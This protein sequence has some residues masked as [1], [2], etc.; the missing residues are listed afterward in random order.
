[1]REILMFETNPEVQEA[2]ERLWQEYQGVERGTIIPWDEIETVMGRS[3]DD[4]SGWHIIRQFRKRLRIEKH[5]TTWKQDS[6]GIR[7][8]THQQTL[9]EMPVIRQRKARRQVTR[10]LKELATVDEKRLTVRERQAL[11]IQRDNLKYER[12]TLGRSYRS[13]AE[14]LPPTQVNPRRKFPVP[15]STLSE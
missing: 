4:V 12:L 9:H 15:E 8:L 6:V 1:L 11:K 3:R 2:I 10:C 13:L 7:C 5:I 14:T